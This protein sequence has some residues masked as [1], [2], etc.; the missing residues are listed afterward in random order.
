M[1][2]IAGR[3]LGLG[4]FEFDE[5][6]SRGQA[7]RVGSQGGVTS[8]GKAGSTQSPRGINK[9]SGQSRESLSREEDER[10]SSLVG[11]K[12]EAESKATIKGGFKGVHLKSFDTNQDNGTR[13]FRE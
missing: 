12:I 1:G 8:V 10:R 9:E 7:Q 5:F 3:R 13:K 6:R 2:F 4:E 11:R